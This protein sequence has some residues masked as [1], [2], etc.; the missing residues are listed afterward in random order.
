MKILVCIKQVPDTTKVE[1]DPKTGSLIRSG[2]DAK[3]NPYDLF[4]L[5][6]AL[7]LK[8]QGLAS[9]E[10]ITMG[11]PNATEVLKEALGL[12]A[13]AGVLLSDRGFAGADVLATSSTLSLAIQTLDRHYDLILCGKQTTDGDTAQVGPAMAEHLGIP[14]IA[15][16]EDIKTIL[17]D[18]MIVTA[19]LTKCVQECAILFPCLLTIEKDYA[20]PRY[21]SYV[22]MKQFDPSSII[23]L[24]LNDLGGDAVKHL[25]GSLGS[26]TSVERI[27]PPENEVISMHCSGKPSEIADQLVDYLNHEHF[28]MRGNV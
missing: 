11:P 20:S 13:D 22:K 2:A 15:W 3:M 25:V 9:V 6:A 21:P 17:K 19:N 4:A 12:G 27:F 23:T 7:R 8:D 28:V 1:I 5:E 14:H 18:G 26:P 16:V 10:V 24:S